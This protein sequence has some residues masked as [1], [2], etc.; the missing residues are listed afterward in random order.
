MKPGELVARGAGITAS[1]L[2]QWRKAYAEDSLAAPGTN[3]P[4][5]GVV[6]PAYADCDD[7]Q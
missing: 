4:V 7:L 1:Q 6:L 3:A 2:L 5:E